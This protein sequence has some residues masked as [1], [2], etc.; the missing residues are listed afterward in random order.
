[1]SSTTV[2]VRRV[3]VADDDPALLTVLSVNLEAEGLVVD[4]V[5]D[6]QA[7][8]EHALATPPDLIILDWMMP[9]RDGLGALAVLKADPATAHIPVV[10]LTAKATDSEVWEGWEAG[11][12]YYITKPFDVEEI[13]H[14]IQS[15]SG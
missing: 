12:D 8:C 6:G 10:L 5:E 7:A 2:A 11:A 13:I 14:F 3:L 4:A 1:M 9:R 15:L